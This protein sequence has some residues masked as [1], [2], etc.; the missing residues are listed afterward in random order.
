MGTRLV[1]VVSAAAAAVACS[2]FVVSPGRVAAGA[3]TAGRPVATVGR[4][5]GASVLLSAPPPSPAAAAPRGAV[6]ATT[7][8]IMPIGDSITRGQAESA[9]SY[10]IEL[11]ERL[12]AA[13]L[14]VDFVGS[15]HS[16]SGAD[17]D[18][19]GHSH[20]TI[21]MITEKIDGWL[22]TYRPDVVLLHIGTNNLQDDAHAAA[23]PGLLATLLRRIAADVP[24][25]DVFVAKVIS[26]KLADRNVRTDAYNA[27]VAE[28][29]AAQGP[30]FHLVD[31]T[32]VGGPDLRDNLHP[33]AF[34]YR[35][36][37]YTWYHAL[38]QVF[39]SPASPWPAGTSPFIV[40]RAYLCEALN[41][42]RFTSP[43]DCRWWYY[44]PVQVTVDGQPVQVRRWQTVR[45][46]AQPYTVAVAGRYTYPVTVVAASG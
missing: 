35:K 19:E 22:A 7:L 39:A 25:A 6:A 4:P 37:A 36:M 11:R 30:R 26:S 16:G 40:T 15:Q 2:T 8:R 13:G 34:G 20:W 21:D 32:A 38:E 18:H 14:K 9:G 43:S 27:Q 3:A 42:A 12:Q 1:R 31:Q 10:R 23:A 24:D 44:R 29:L 46:V 33:N 41:P 45:L 28:L 17:V 5:E